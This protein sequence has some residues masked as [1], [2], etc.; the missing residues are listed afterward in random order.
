VDKINDIQVSH[1]NNEKNSKIFSLTDIV[2][3]KYVSEGK[4]NT[5]TITLKFEYNSDNEK[6]NYLDIQYS[7][8]ILE[9]HVEFNPHVLRNI[10]SYLR[11]KLLKEEFNIRF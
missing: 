2:F 10:D 5:G 8:R 11:S 1:L 4:S 3:L 6:I 9:K 7:D